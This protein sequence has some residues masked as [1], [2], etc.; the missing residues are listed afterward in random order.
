MKK[1]RAPM[2]MCINCR[3]MK[4]KLE[5]LRLVKSA[6]AKLVEIDST[7]KKP[8]RGAYVCKEKTCAEAAK[9]HK[10]VERAFGITDCGDLY[11]SLLRI[12]GVDDDKQ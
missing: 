12:T 4:P 1:K 7:G 10:K 8:G 9:K 11:N 6:D 3:S 5:M 2:R